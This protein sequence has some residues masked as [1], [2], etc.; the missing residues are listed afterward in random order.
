MNG[1]FFGNYQGAMVRKEPITMQPVNPESDEV[2]CRK[3][4]LS[5]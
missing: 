5:G 1:I 3:Q 2:L 4:R